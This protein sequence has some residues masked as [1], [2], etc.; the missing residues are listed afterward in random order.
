MGSG[1]GF[2][3]ASTNLASLYHDGIGVAVDE[4]KMLDLF[5][6]GARQGD[7]YADAQLGEIY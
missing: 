7:S 6:L 5:K 2:A 1:L 4:R 3:A